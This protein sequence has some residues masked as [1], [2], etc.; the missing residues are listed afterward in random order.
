MKCKQ[1]VVEEF[2]SVLFTGM[3]QKTDHLKKYK[4]EGVKV[5]QGF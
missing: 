3:S 5:E 2:Q 1:N 4:P